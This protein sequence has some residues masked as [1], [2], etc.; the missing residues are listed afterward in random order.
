MVALN[1]SADRL[2]TIDCSSRFQSDFIQ[3]KN[4]SCLCW[5]LQEIMKDEECLYRD[6]YQKCTRRGSGITFIRPRY[7][8]SKNIRKLNNSILWIK[9]TKGP[10][11]YITEIG[12]CLSSLVIDTFSFAILLLAW[13]LN[14]KRIV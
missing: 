4:D 12:L 13:I 9:K 2:I 11:Q 5:V 8:Q 3:R 7:T 6:R 10:K 14:S 1:V